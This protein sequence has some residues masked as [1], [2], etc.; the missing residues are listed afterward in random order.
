MK[1][2]KQQA[3]DPRVLLKSAESAATGKEINKSLSFF[4]ECIREYL[5]RQLPFKAIAVAKRAKTALGPIPKASGLAHRIYTMLGFHG[6]ARREYETAAS[7]LKKETL[8]FFK[9]LDEET[10]IG[11]LPVM[12][13][14]SY[15]KG[16]IVIKRHEKG[17]DVFMVLSGSCEVTREAKRLGVMKPGDL[18]G[19]IGF[20]AQTPRTAS[21]KTLEKCTLIRIASENLSRLKERHPILEQNLEN[22]YGSRILKK[23]TEDLETDDLSSSAP[24]VTSTLQYGKGQDIPVHPEDSMAILKHGIVEVDY[25]DMCLRR[26]E[27]L[28][29]GTVIS[30]KRAR[31]KASTD[32]EIVLAKT[33]R[34]KT[35]ES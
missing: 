16:R 25:D 3:V 35:K 14:I 7:F 29:P 22:I 30:N 27:Y 33:A 32:V 13:L 8:A 10:F 6:D 17:R 11:L 34:H 12:D 20:L 18:F 2:P 23:V 15:P 24:E 19:E 5:K 28:K 26:K 9:E 21:V 4:E 31:A 1:K